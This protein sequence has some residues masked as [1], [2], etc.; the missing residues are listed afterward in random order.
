MEYEAAV[1]RLGVLETL[2]DFD[3]RVVGTLPL[4][5]FVPGSD[6]DIV[7]HAFD[8]IGF[9]EVIWKQYQSCDGFS[10]YQWISK[11][12][13]VIA[14]FNWR[15]WRFEVF[16]EA[17]PV[18]QQRGWRHFEVERRLLVLDDGRLRDAVIR[19]RS[20]GTKTEPAFA[21]ALGIPGDPYLGM[22]DLADETDAQLRARLRS[23]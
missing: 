17:K 1:T 15:G 6:I 19:Q 7:C 12:G 11:R 16:G 3:P 2:R 18:D 22:L 9:A 21:S 5:L 10:L 8:P 23:L 13:P 20:L 14:R 4:G